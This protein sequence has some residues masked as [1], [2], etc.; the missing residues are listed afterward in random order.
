MARIL[1]R[2]R[3]RLLVNTLRRGAQAVLALVLGLVFGV[4]G[5][6]L[7]AAW[8][9]STSDSALWPDAV[10]V[11][12]A[13]GFAGWLLL[14]MLS[15]STD[16]TLDPRKFAL[17]PVRPARLVPGLFLGALVGVGPVATLVAT[18]GVVTG[19]SRLSGSVAAAAV[20]A[21]AAVLFVLACVV[22]SRALLAWASDALTSRRGRD[23]ATVVAA[24]LTIAFVAAGQV[25]P[26]LGAE[27]LSAEVLQQTA[28]VARFSPGGAA[29]LAAGAAAAGRLGE[30]LAW[31]ALLAAWIGL[32][33]LVWTVAVARTRTTTPTPSAGSPTGRA[34]LYPRALA[35]LPRNRTTA[36]AV[37]FLRSLIRDPR[38]RTQA[39][40]Q[41]FIIVPMLA[42][43]IG[44]LRGGAAPLIATFLVVPFGLMAAN[45]Y[46]LEG[47]A[48]W[49]HRLAGEDPRSDILGRDLALGLLGLPLA[50][51]VAV[52][53]AGIFDV[54][55][56]LPMALL[57]ALATL[58]SLL[59]VSNAASV[60]APYPVPEDA[61]NPF[62]SNSGSP[63]SG[64]LQG[65][66]VVVTLV[67]HGLIS[68][69]VVLAATLPDTVGGRTAA[70]AAAVVYGL[71]LLVVGTTLAV[72]RARSRGPELL[73]SVDPRRQ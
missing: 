23:L 12:L 38:V 47:P 8:L 9:G 25:L 28:A 20:A 13:T 15:F 43:S 63:G 21:V 16:D 2:L 53:V 1:L 39:M 56:L 72:G 24:L 31:S 34:G 67:V 33:L 73:I 51:I 14:P 57:L 65:L 6:A 70:A 50:V 17:F 59:G 32:M 35:W 64:C 48:L 36:V 71:G 40:S 54:W 61:G 11:V 27:L 45:Q 19:A 58:L 66:L 37:R 30:G 18:S 26:R 5:G 62:A 42:I 22:S 44:G 41:A 29:G 10:V 68:V 46:G 7:V 49:Q 60:L 3:L 52:V 69:P 55:D 4:G